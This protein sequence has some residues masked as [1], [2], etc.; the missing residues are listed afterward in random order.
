MGGMLYQ[1]HELTRNLLAPWVHQAQANAKMFSDPDSLWASLPG[2]ERMAASNE[3]F[4]RLGKEYEKPAWALDDVE[5]DGHSL[6]IIERE[7]LSK[8]FCRLLR[9]KRFSDHVEL[10]GK[11]KEQPAVLVVAPLSGHHATLL[12]DTVRTLL[13]NHKVYVTDWVDARMVP[14]EAGAFRLEDYITYIQEFI[15][16]IGAERL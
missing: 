11:M 10:I 2:A 4:H 5:V 14:L 3:L 8:P 16:H 7:V 6:P 9:F 13:R 12:R 15:R 1:L